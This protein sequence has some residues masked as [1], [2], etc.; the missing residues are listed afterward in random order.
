MPE[1]STAWIASVVL[2][3]RAT[4]AGGKFWLT[5]SD[6]ICNGVLSLVTIPLRSISLAIG[7][8]QRPPVWRPGITT[9]FAASCLR[10]LCGK[11]SAVGVRSIFCV[12]PTLTSA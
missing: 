4:N 9:S 2:R 8:V 5:V 3:L 6:E 12:R 7:D 11:P 1:I 10:S